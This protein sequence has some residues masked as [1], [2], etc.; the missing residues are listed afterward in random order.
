I[1]SISYFFIL[2]LIISP[3]ISIIFL[4]RTYRNI[5]NINTEK[6]NEI[7][8][9]LPRNIQ[10]KIIENLKALNDRIKEQLKNE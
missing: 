10:I 8:K 4:I 2:F 5:S 6:L 9:P 7:L 1:M 3:T